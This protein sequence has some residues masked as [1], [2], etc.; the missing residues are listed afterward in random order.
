MNTDPDLR[1]G[2]TTTIPVEAVFAAGRR[3]VD[4]NNLF[5]AARDPEADVRRA[6]ARGFPRSFCAWVKGL[7]G[8]VLRTGVPAVVGVTRGD[9]SGTESLLE[10]LS[11]EGIEVLPF[12]FPERP[13]PQAVEDAVRA[14]CERLGTDLASARAQ[15]ERL[16]PVRARA[17]ELDRLAWRQGTVRGPEL[18]DALL[19]TSDFRGDPE[20]YAAQLDRTLAQSRARNPRAQG[21]RLGLLGVPPIFSDLVEALEARAARVAFHEIPRQFALPEG[22][23]TLGEAYARYTYPYGAAGRVADIAAQTR[24]RG[25]HGL[26]HYVQSFCH[27]QVHDRLVREA[28]DVPVLT[29]E[30]DR[31][32][33]IDARTVTRIEA[34]LETL[35]ARWG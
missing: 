22:R 15:K 29:V 35:E 8:T 1:I 21:L 3:P 20:A 31:P 4:L 25:L 16:D 6:E 14:L 2:I 7:Y 19:N 32:G 18:F 10:I 28:V 27:R 24:R 17:L 11:A 26:V 5:V 12:G 34:F 30:G 33:P 9:C 23:G 13:E